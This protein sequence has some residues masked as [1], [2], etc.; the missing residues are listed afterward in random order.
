MNVSTP[1]KNHPAEIEVGLYCTFIA[2]Y[3]NVI[4]LWAYRDVG[5]R[6]NFHSS[7]AWRQEKVHPYRYSVN[8]DQDCYYLILS[9]WISRTISIL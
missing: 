5:L 2:S 1:A 3:R 8:Q 7:T 9:T 4:G 6:A